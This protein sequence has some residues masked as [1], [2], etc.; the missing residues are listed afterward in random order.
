MNDQ[1]LYVSWGSS[2]A[3]LVIALAT[4]CLHQGVAGDEP[5]TSTD[6]T[7]F[8]VEASCIYSSLITEKSHTAHATAEFS[9]CC[10]ALWSHISSASDTEVVPLLRAFY[11]A[12]EISKTIVIRNR[13]HDWVKLLLAGLLTVLL[14]LLTKF[15]NGPVEDSLIASEGSSAVLRGWVLFAVSH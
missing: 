4:E 9:K 15:F 12:L 10:L 5:N 8:P 1:T 11:I 2:T 6:C 14:S 7:S 3:E 13:L